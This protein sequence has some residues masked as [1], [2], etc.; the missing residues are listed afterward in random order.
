[1]PSGLILQNA[2]KEIHFEL[3][4]ITNQWN[5]NWFLMVQIYIWADKLLV[6]NRI[7]INYKLLQI[8]LQ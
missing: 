8:N 6:Y 5:R 1:M 3:Y 2:P 7:I 4:N